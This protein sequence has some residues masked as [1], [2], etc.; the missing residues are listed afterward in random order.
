MP[1]EGLGRP[2]KSWSQP[3][4]QPLRL[5][6]RDSSFHLT[7]SFK[8]L[9]CSNVTIT[10][11][12]HSHLLS[13]VS[14]CLAHFPA[15]ARHSNTCQ[16]YDREDSSGLS[17]TED[18]A[19]VSYNSV[20]SSPWKRLTVANNTPT[21]HTGLRFITSAMQ[22]ATCKVGPATRPRKLQLTKDQQLAKAQS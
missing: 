5:P 4:P 19:K 12:D 10:A 16:I 13:S 8:E 21:P 11:W 6:R 14:P 15:H 9:Q 18:W 20:A 2:G 22:T 3:C 7:N 17:G 1:R